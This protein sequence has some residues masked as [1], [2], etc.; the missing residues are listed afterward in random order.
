MLSELKSY[1]VRELNPSDQ[2]ALWDMLYHSLYVAP[3]HA[4]FPRE[5]VNRPEIA[6][7]VEA[8]G[9]AGDLGFVAIDSKSNQTVGAA[10]LRLLTDHRKGY[11]YVDD[12]TPEL[13]IA[14]LPDYR[15]QGIGSELLNRL[16]ETAGTNYERVSLSVSADNPA[17]RLY[18]RAG[19]ERVAM[20]DDSVTML[21]RIRS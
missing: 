15:G 14:V 1:F 16:L 4:P 18:Q 6:K 19:F 9:R 13:G 11:G 12:D 3:G 7:Y 21:K 5:I 2:E 20:S 10:W 8:W 17:M